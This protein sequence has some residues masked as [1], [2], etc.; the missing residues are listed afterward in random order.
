MKVVA[1]Q[2]VCFHVF[3]I[4]SCLEETQLSDS[5]KLG[6][7]IIGKI[8][9]KKLFI[10]IK[11]ILNVKGLEGCPPDCGYFTLVEYSC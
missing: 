3:F 11:E 9:P 6:N 1:K 4:G 8:Y 7:S 5:Q 2:I 10:L